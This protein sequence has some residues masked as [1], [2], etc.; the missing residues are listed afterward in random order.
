MIRSSEI[1]I[2]CNLDIALEFL[3]ELATISRDCIVSYMRSWRSMSSFGTLPSDVRMLL[4]RES[5]I[6]ACRSVDT[7]L[8]LSDR[9]AL[10]CTVGCER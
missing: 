1:V 7:S 9:K 8:S 2:L 3:P 6:L 4:F 5:K 10:A